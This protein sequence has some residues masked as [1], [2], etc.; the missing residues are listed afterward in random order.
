MRVDVVVEQLARPVPGGIGVWVREVTPR[1]ARRH[2]V[3]L[4]SSRSARLGS[5]RDVAT[6]VRLIPLPEP[7]AQRAWDAGLWGTDPSADVGLWLSFGGPRIAPRPPSVV[8]VHDTIFLEHPELYTARGARWHEAQLGAALDR[9]TRLVAVDPTVAERLAA[10]GVGDRVRVVAPGADHLPPADTEGARSVLARAGVERPYLLVVGTLEPRK[11]LGRLIEA[12][13]CYRARS[14]DPVDLVVVGPAGWGDAA[15]SSPGVCVVGRVEAPILA[16]LLV[17]ARALAYV[18]L[19][20]GFGLPV[21]EALHAA[22][23][24]VV[25]TTVPAARYGGVRVDPLDVQAIADGLVE[26]LDD[27]RA[28][29]RL[30]S[31]GLLAVESLSWDRTTSA[32]A[33]VLEEVANG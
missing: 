33:D 13:Q 28:R 23:P 15:V 17:H 25:S 6:R 1:L 24:V 29:S 5:L 30:V 26:V 16:G 10:L 32:L 4:V 18:S 14:F 11:N 20:E 3:R 21:V 9:A 22:V 19:V 27:E 12:Y 8:V 7:I 2:D 31:E